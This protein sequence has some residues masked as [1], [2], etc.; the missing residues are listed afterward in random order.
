MARMN[1]VL[2]IGLIVALMMS[3]IVAFAQQ[4]GKVEIKGSVVD[5]NT[6]SPL[7]FA[8]VL[9]RDTAGKVVQGETTDSKGNY[10]LMAPVGSWVME[11]AFIG[12]TTDKLDVTITPQRVH[13]VPDKIEIFPEDKEIDA[14]VVTGK[15]PPIERKIDMLVMNVESIISA[16]TSTGLELLKQAPGVSIDNE[17]NITLKG[18][19]VQIWIDGRPSHLSGQEL[20]ALLEST[21]GAN[22]DKIEIINNPSS[23]YDAAGGGGI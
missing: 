19:S 22:I 13:N 7:E 1:G 9:L 16:E 12:Y 8:T 10:T 15:K 3:S 6:G 21:E 14:V 11:V 17:G 4:N 2:R 18:E 23:K 5:K 20:V